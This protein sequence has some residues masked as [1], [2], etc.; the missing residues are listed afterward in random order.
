M[1]IYTTRRHRAKSFMDDCPAATL[2]LA[3]SFFTE[4]RDRLRGGGSLAV[5]GIRENSEVANETLKLCKAKWSCWNVM[6]RGDS[7]QVH[8]IERPLR[9]IVPIAEIFL[10]FSLF[11]WNTLSW[12]G[13]E[14]ANKRA[15]TRGTDVYTAKSLFYDLTFK[16]YSVFF[17]ARQLCSLMEDSVSQYSEGYL[18]SI[19]QQWINLA[20]HKKTCSELQE[21]WHSGFCEIINFLWF[22]QDIRYDLTVYKPVSYSVFHKTRQVVVIGKY[23]D[24]NSKR[25]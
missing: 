4:Q 22:Q 15:A 6:S 19:Q 20:S 23:T 2:F 7:P 13:F 3:S 14:M 8:H 17:R 10:V 16:L 1:G 11:V 24:K 5:W 25:P 9:H 12:W 18:S 21:T